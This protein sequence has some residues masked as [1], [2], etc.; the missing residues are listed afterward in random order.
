VVPVIEIEEQAGARHLV[1]VVDL[2]ARRCA[3]FDPT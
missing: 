1:V 2:G 3:T